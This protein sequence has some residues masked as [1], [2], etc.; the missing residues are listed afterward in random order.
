MNDPFLAIFD[1]LC[2]WLEQLNMD[3]VTIIG[4]Y[5]AITGALAVLEPLLDKAIAKSKSKAD[6]AAWAKVKP[7][8]EWA[9]AGVYFVQRFKRQ[10]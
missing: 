8:L 5:I 7:V 4:G 2:F 1:A 10:G 9:K 3:P 6:D